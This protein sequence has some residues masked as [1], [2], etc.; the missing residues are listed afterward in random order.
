MKNPHI[1][2]DTR[3]NSPFILGSVDLSSTNSVQSKSMLNKR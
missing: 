2:L 3:R 1:D